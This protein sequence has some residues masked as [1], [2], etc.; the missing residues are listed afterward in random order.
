MNV[1]APN[2]GTDRVQ[3]FTKLEHI[4]KQQRDGDVIVL[5]GDW[6]CTLNFTQDRNGE[7]PHA[8]SA[9]F[10]ANIIKNLDFSDIWREHNLSEQQ[11]TWMKVCNGRVFGACLDRFYISHNG[12]NK[13]INTAIFPTALSDHKLI[14][15]GC[16]LTERA[17]KSYYWHLNVKLLE[18]K[19]IL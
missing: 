5:G 19:H 8:Q 10:L 15:V 13:V 18:D 11:Y 6:N 1:Y 3:F 9:L 12:R 16:M 4:L 14:T 17:H 2:T 7:E